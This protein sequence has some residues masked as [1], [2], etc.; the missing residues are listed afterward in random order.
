M[1]LIAQLLRFYL[2]YSCVLLFVNFFEAG[3]KL[4]IAYSLPVD[5][6]L[7]RLTHAQTLRLQMYLLVG[8]KLSIFVLL[9]AMFINR[10]CFR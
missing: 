4:F 5:N 8:Y 6:M 1:L 3:S 7:Y 2:T 9:V 10:K